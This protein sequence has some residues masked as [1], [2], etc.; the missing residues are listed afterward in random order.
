[1]APEYVTVEVKNEETGEVTKKKV[2]L[3]DISGT[4][5]LDLY[6]GWNP[7]TDHSPNHK[8]AMVLLTLPPKVCAL[9][10]LERL[11]V[12]HNRLSSLPEAIEGLLNLKELFL[13]RNNFESVPVE[14]CRLPSLEILWMNGNK[15][16][17]IPEE[18]SNLKTLKRLHLDSNFVEEFPD[19][20]CQL[21]SL[22][23]LYLNHNSLHCISD[24]IGKLTELKR[25]YL[26]HNKISS[27]PRGV[28]RLSKIEMLLLDHNEITQVRREFQ[29]YQAQREATTAVISLKNNPF[30]VPPSRMKLSI[31]SYPNPRSLSLT[32]KARRHSEQVERGQ[33]LSRRPRVSLPE[34]EI[35]RALGAGYSVTLPRVH[36]TRQT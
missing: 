32:M 9:T 17:S 34:S 33:L 1:M 15:I 23:V 22:E 19:A 26:Q 10:H 29:H 31:G 13:H 30:V 14:L 16:T 18:V 3:T 24:D 35:S 8:M 5:T 27:I 7:E 36:T 2:Y 25:L 20:L 11:W 12:S 28:C 6:S 21:E 4:K